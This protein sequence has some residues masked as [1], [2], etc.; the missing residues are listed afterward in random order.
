MAWQPQEEPLRQLAGLLKDSL[1]HYNP[2]AQ[3]QA[4][5]ALG[6]AKSYPDI[7]NYLAYLTVCRQPPDTINLVGEDLNTARYAAAIMLKNNMRDDYKKTSEESLTYIRA[8]I[9]LGVQD[10]DTQIRNLTGNVITELSRQGGLLGWRELLPE[11]LAMAGNDAGT[12]APEA[13]EG[14]MGALAKVCED[15]RKALD[16][17]IQGQRPLDVIIP[18]LLGFTISPLPKVRALALSTILGFI[19]QMP[20]SLLLGLDS[21]MG[22]LLQLANDPDMEVRRNVCRAF[23][24][25]A[26]VRPEKIA[27]YMEGLVDYI[28]AQQRN[29]VDEELAVDAAEFWLSIGEH[30]ALRE[31]VRPYLPKVVPALLDGMVYSEDDIVELGGEGEDAQEDDKAE[32]IKPQFA[33]SKAAKNTTNGQTIVATNGAG[34]ASASDARLADLDEDD[35]SEGEIDEDA[36]DE[37]GEDDLEAS[38]NLRKCSGAALDVLASV[39]HRNV[40]DV[41]LPYLK[42][43]L[44]HEEWPRRE[45]AVLALGAI[46]TGC[47]DLVQPHL[48]DLVPYLLSLLNDPEPVVRSITCWTL[49]R[50]SGWAVH[51]DGA[52]A[53]TQYFEPMMEGLLTKMLDNNKRVQEAA[54]AAFAVL[55]EQATQQLMPYCEPIVQHFVRCFGKY[56][57]KN[58]YLLYNCVQ[59]LAEHVGPVLARPGTV[60]PL[61]SALIQRWNKLSDQSRELVSL[62]ECFSF[63]VMALGTH[64][65]T[66]A[67]PLFTRCLR[68]IHESL[69]QHL[70]AMNDHSVDPPDME[71]VVT[72]L[73]LVGGI[74]QAVT[75]NKMAELMASAQPPFFE[76]LAFCMKHE[77]N[78]AV[79]QSAYAVLGDC[80]I[81]QPDQ[82]KPFLTALVPIVLR[83]LDLDTVV[84][85]QSLGGSGVLSNACWSSGEICCHLPEATA[86]YVEDLYQR[87]YSVVLSPDV[88]VS[89]HENA[90]VALGRLGMGAPG[91]LAP[92]LSDFAE[93]F[94]DALE[95][96]DWTEEKDTAFEGFAKV[97]SLNPRA[98]EQCLPKY[99]EAIARYKIH[100]HPDAPGNERLRPLFHDTITGYRQMIPNFQGFLSQLDP[101]DQQALRTTYQL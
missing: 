18:K 66:F 96:V 83:Q 101:S 9:L 23:V 2:T 84:N 8:S 79:R 76:L 94:L 34:V 60:E 75:P 47:L 41:T 49:G 98:M 48:P 17:D 39:Y 88:P 38:W 81:N 30:E 1:S 20:Q 68:I 44:R 57:D 27:P 56:K 42:Q 12:V 62:L 32:D 73:D 19:P 70:A 26:E 31:H 58:I 99:F 52:E 53:K 13:Q 10:S 55:E 24:S 16:R 28:I 51:L 95:R 15:N 86:G 69:G 22:R 36:E 97:V 3:K 89:V 6:Q 33:K 78:P 61:M 74:V 100:A 92:H 77:E 21:L 40:F 59:T 35:L 7:N 45:A 63:V 50:Y 80:A 65:E 37:D 54:S 87:L 71:F 72:S 29:E 91:T 82:L 11:L 64:V 67:A 14:A 5:L 90:A 93:G 4:T 43:N 25:I 85:E 46:A